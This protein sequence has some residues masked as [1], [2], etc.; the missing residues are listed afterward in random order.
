MKKAS[1]I[2]KGIVV[3]IILTIVLIFSVQNLTSIDIRFLNKQTVEIPLFA[4]IFGVLILGILVGY[5]LGL[6]SGSKISKQKL[7]EISISANEKLIEMSNK[8]KEENKN[9][10][11]E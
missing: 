8:L 2:I 4:I 1:N 9:K 10:P 7:N 11:S 3:A 6:I 5:L